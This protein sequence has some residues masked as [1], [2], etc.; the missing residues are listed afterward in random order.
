MRSTIGSF[1]LKNLQ[2]EA[3]TSSVEYLKLL[4]DFHVPMHRY[5]KFNSEDEKFNFLLDHMVAYM[6]GL[7][8]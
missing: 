1:L 6:K 2:K 8:N 7:I 4:S 5:N 3:N